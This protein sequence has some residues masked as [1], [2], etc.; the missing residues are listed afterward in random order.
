MRTSVCDNDF[1]ILI[2]AR[3]GSKGVPHKNRK[4]L[5]YTLNSIPT[6]H[7][8]KIWV[9]TDD[10]FI[11]DICK[12][13]DIRIHDR[14]PNTA[15]DNASS[16][17][18]L[19]EFI[20]EQRITKTIICL[21]LT[22]P[23]RTWEDISRAY[24]FYK[25]HKATSLLCRKEVKQ[26][27]YLMLEEVNTIYGKQ[28]INHNLYRRQDY[29]KVF[30]ICHF[31]SIIEPWKF[32]DLNNNLYNERTIFFPINPKIDIDTPA[33]LENFLKMRP[34]TS[35]IVNKR[36]EKQEVPKPNT[37]EIINVNNSIEVK[38]KG[39]INNAKLLNGKIKTEKSRLINVD[40]FAKRI[41]NKRVCLVANS[42][43]LLKEELGEYIDGH[44]FVIRFNSF[45]IDEK[46]TGKKINMHACIYLEHRNCNIP[47]DFRF[48]ISVNK[49]RWDD[50]VSDIMKMNNCDVI[51][52]NWPLNLN[53]D[54]ILGRSIP[55]TGLNVLLYLL[56]CKGYKEINI[57]GF[58][59]YE[60]GLDSIYRLDGPKSHIS[61]VHDYANEQDWINKNTKPLKK[62]VRSL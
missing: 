55:S 50:R 23:E 43:D 29:P 9:S 17:Q 34:A 27:P 15:S 13:H 41:K 3:A 18:M 32:R 44:D 12:Q 22:Y 36:V 33:D 31:I 26:H 19:H 42:S 6:E 30:E 35:V 45:V 58:N 39:E 53:A 4:L 5:S 38:S 10:P 25:S 16:K 11:K 28:I 51:N 49:K 59:C 62:Y 48:V 60:S 57:V 21:Y 52:C 8:S 14:K 24:N 54:K 61:T 40:E 47:V 1:I 37:P 56:H 7:W 46:H 2:P 20:H